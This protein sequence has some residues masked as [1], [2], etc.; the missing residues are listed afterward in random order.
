[1]DRQE[2]DAL[3]N[4]VKHAGVWLESVL[5]DL[6]PVLNEVATAIQAVA[7]GLAIWEQAERL[8]AQ[9]WV[10]HYTTPFK[11]AAAHLN[12]TK[13]LK[14]LMLAHYTDNWHR[15]STQIKVRLETYRIDDDARAALLEALDGHEAG[16]YRS[17]PRLLFPEIERLLRDALFGGKTEGRVRYA[18]FVDALVGSGTSAATGEDQAGEFRLDLADFMASGIHELQLFR[19]VAEQPMSR[20]GR[21]H[22]EDLS[23]GAY[24]PSIFAKVTDANIEAARQSPIPT[25]HAT[26]HGLVIYS[27]KQSSLNAIFIADY[28]FSVVSRLNDGRASAAGRQN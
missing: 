19:Y 23:A 2:A 20:Q 26:M 15:V 1:M 25:R 11:L 17:V 8:M 13:A 28:M 7:K 6:E 27:T 4:A 21:R 18:D 22:G 10:P 14:R 9:G 12:D 3:I 24:V 16:H 5:R